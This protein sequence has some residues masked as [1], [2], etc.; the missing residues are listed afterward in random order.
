VFGLEEVLHFGLLIGGELEFLGQFL[1]A[2]GGIGRAVA[3]ATVVL[4]GL[5]I[6]GRAVVGRLGRRERRGDRDEAGR[7]KISFSKRSVC[8]YECNYEPEVAR[9][10][11]FG[12][13]FA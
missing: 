8:I 1:G 12:Q 6:A 4:R 7:E 3:P 5:L 9:G 10:T 2:L 13:I 11:G